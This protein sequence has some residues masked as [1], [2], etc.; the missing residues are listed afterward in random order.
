MLSRIKQ[1]Q[2]GEFTVKK[3]SLRFPHDIGCEDSAIEKL[4]GRLGQDWLES[5]CTV[6]L[7]VCQH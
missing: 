2:R 5:C 7:V 6:S 1:N 3:Y 4:G